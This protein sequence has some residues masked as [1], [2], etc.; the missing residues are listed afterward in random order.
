M[1]YITSKQ[2]LEQQEKFV[3][4]SYVWEQF[5]DC[6]IVEYVHKINEQCK[7]GF[8]GITNV[9][10]DVVSNATDDLHMRQHYIKSMAKVYGSCE[11]TIALIPECRYI[12]DT[13]QY[14]NIIYDIFMS[15]WFTRAWTLQ[16]QMVSKKIYV[17]INNELVDITKEVHLCLTLNYI[18]ARKEWINMMKLRFS[19]MKNQMNDIYKG[20]NLYEYIFSA[21]VPSIYNQIKDMCRRAARSQLT[22]IE[23]INLAARRVMGVDNKNLEPIIGMIGEGNN[24]PDSKYTRIDPHILVSNLPKSKEKNMC[25]L[26]T[27]LRYNAE[28]QYDLR[29]KVYLLDNGMLNI[30]EVSYGWDIYII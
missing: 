30:R 27:Q 2:V 3:A 11:F 6:N 9:W 4:I 14:E 10:L 7:G 13:N 5:T 23:A 24:I 12:G 1:Q 20:D 17:S 18:G 22:K 16:E 21:M 25:W 15:Q 19:K 26:P 8:K 28:D 29:I